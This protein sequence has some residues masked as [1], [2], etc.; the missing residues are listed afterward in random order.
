MAGGALVGAAVPCL[1]PCI[2]IAGS[3]DGAPS[4]SS[5][6]SGPGTSATDLGRY[7][8]RTLWKQTG[9]MHL[10]LR[11]SFKD[12]W[13]DWRCTTGSLLLLVPPAC[14]HRG[15]NGLSVVCEIG[16][17][18]EES[19]ADVDKHILDYFTYKAVKTVLAQLSE[20][21]PQQ[22]S[23][24]YNFVVNNRPQDS[25]YF[26][27]ILVKEK[28]ELGERVMVTRLHLFNN[29]VKKY[30]HAAMHKAISEQNLEILRERLIQTVKLTSDGDDIE[31]PPFRGS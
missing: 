25:K 11:T 5:C 23:W 1:R 7:R 14:G 31:R 16:G 20:M 17:N 22:Y 12:S 13:Q 2:S 21:N 15:R 30:N 27:R 19:F 26:L 24:F 10:D 4:S 29:W 28:Q 3:S 8:K 6:R 18:Y 9:A